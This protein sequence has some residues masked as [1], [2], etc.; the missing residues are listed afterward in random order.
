MSKKVRGTTTT[1]SLPINPNMGNNLKVTNFDFGNAAAGEAVFNPEV[2]TTTFDLHSVTSNNITQT[3]ANTY[4]STKIGTTKIRQIDY[5]SGDFT[6]VA[7]SNTAIFDAYIFDT[8]FAPITMNV[9]TPYTSGS[10]DITLERAK[11]TTV[12]DAYN[13]AKITLG[14]ETREIIDYAESFSLGL[15]DG[16]GSIVLDSTD[17]VLDADDDILLEFGG[18]TLNLSFSTSADISNTVT[19]N[20]STREIESLAIANSTNGIANTPSMDI[21]LSSKVNVNDRASNTTLFDTD[22]NS[23]VFPIGIDNV[24]SLNNEA[25]TF[26]AKK[27][28]D[29]TFSG[30]GPTAT[31][32]APSNFTFETEGKSSGTLESPKA[33]YLVYAT[34]SA[35]SL[36][37]STGSITTGTN[38]IAYGEIVDVTIGVNSG[39]SLTLTPTRNGNTFTAGSFTAKVY[40]TVDTTV[41]RMK[42]QKHLVSATVPA[43]GSNIKDAAPHL[44]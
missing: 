2:L 39:T 12:A 18:A 42:K 13:G 19:L 29:A 11:S 24:K 23:L 16:L 22:L 20:F 32:T 5:S 40:A 31:I 43:D 14:S 25:L 8:Q 33:N 17:G 44:Q 3:S 26:Q 30:S 7:V 35:A 15:E 4:N 38:Y 28:I 37:N 6:N 9:G 27:V 34:N 1:T 21:D 41:H 10:T 36:A